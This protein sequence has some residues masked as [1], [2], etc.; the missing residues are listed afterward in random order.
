MKIS[1]SRPFEGEYPISFGFGAEPVEDEVVER[2]RL[3]GLVGHNGVDFALPV[4]VSVTAAASGIVSKVLTTGDY[5]NAIMI[6]HELCQT[7]YAHLQSICVVVGQKVQVGDRIGLSGKSGFTIGAHLHFGLLPKDADNENGYLGYVDPLLYMK[8]ESREWKVDTRGKHAEIEKNS[9][10]EQTK[11]SS[12]VEEKTMQGEGNNRRQESLAKG[13]D[14][15]S[16]KRRETIDKVYDY[17]KTNGP[18]SS[19]AIRTELKLSK[20]SVV[21][22]INLLRAAGKIRAIGEKTKVHYEAV[23]AQSS[24][25]DPSLLS[26]ISTWFNG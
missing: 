15:S 12:N 8:M 16:K 21:R 13:R 24:S 1:L 10:K 4:G 9:V 22:F 23:Q 11:E 18:V 25:P 5:G 3:W 26:S 2:Y 14:T 17:I 7:L 20:T 19:R 6:D